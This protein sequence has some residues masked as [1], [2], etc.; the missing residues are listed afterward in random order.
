[1]KKKIKALILAIFI[2]ISSFF[3]NLTTAFATVP[4]IV[5]AEG[6]WMTLETLALT[7]GVSLDFLPSNTISHNNSVQRQ[8]F[9]DDLNK[10]L[11]NGTIT[12]QEYDDSLAEFDQYFQDPL[13]VGD[14]IS[15]S[16]TLFNS[17]SHFFYDNYFVTGVD[18]TGYLS[19]DMLEI[20]N[21]YQGRCAIYRVIDKN[22]AG[23]PDDTIVVLGDGCLENPIMFSDPGTYTYW[24]LNQGNASQGW[25]G[26]GLRLGSIGS[27]QIYPFVGSSVTVQF[28]AHKGLNEQPEVA[29]EGA[30]A[31]FPTYQ[32]YSDTL[33]DIFSVSDGQM[34]IDD[35]PPVVLDG[36]TI[37][38]TVAGIQDGTTTWEDAMPTV[39]EAD[40]AGTIEGEN[41]VINKRAL[42]EMVTGLRLNRLKTK[43]PF[44]I[45][46]DIYN[47]VAGAGALDDEAPVI[48]IPIHIEFRGHVY[49]D[50]DEAVVIDFNEFQSVINV[51]RAG[52]FL[53]FL[54]G[55]IYLTIEVLHSFF[56]V[57]E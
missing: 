55:M 10:Q 9:I 46:S 53:L 23:Y 43:F 56:V 45:P 31:T 18:L 44:C 20:W 33:R 36:E 35:N 39:F 25:L 29:K 30:L 6:I 16:P 26:N 24:Y 37:A 22:Q 54:I 3:N 51:F 57:T 8:L 32:D 17:L 4:G 27:G 40:D 7:F 49:Y 42:D 48:K 5:E 14:A 47:M 2:G 38:D 1:M 52:F 19:D 50:D 28:F 21:N 34:V 41:P 13:S 12:Q 15:I 11:N